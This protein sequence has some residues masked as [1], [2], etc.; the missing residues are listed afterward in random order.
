M[1]IELPYAKPIIKSKMNLFKNKT[2][3]FKKN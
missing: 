3:I 2:D 1:I